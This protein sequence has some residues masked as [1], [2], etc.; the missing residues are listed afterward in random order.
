MD[1]VFHKIDFISWKKN[2]RCVEYA[3]YEVFAVLHSD[4]LANE[5][6]LLWNR[7]C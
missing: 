5:N 7:I 4:T 1:V 6:N 3:S 2:E